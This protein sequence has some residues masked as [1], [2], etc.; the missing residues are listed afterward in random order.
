MRKA[1]LA[2]LA[3]LSLAAIAPAAA[4]AAT[5]VQV[6]PGI[7]AV[8][9]VNNVVVALNVSL[10]PP[11]ITTYLGHAT[12]ATC[13]QSTLKGDFFSPACVTNGPIYPSR[14]LLPGKTNVLQQAHG[15]ANGTA[16]VGNEQF[17]YNPYNNQYYF[18]YASSCSAPFGCTTAFTIHWTNYGSLTGTAFGVHFWNNNTALTPTVYGNLNSTRTQ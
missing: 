3:S 14:G 10:A 11:S 7:T 6:G 9:T 4:S 1:L 13:T 18:I 2:V 15:L 8:A 5:S 17:V 12:G 16:S